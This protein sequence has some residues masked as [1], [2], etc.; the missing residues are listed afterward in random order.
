R[1]TR[2]KRDWSSDVCSSDLVQISG[3]MNGIRGPTNENEFDF[4]QYMAGKKVF[5]QLQAKQIKTFTKFHRNTI[6][7][8]FHSL[9]KKI[10]DYLDKMP[11]PL[12]WFIQV[13]LIGYQSENFQDSMDQINKLGLLYLFTLSGMHVYYLISI[14][15]YV[16]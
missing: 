5:N 16:T 13:L 8:V 6:F 15:R 7:S 14:V 3:K 12:G 4:R 9:R 11:Q 2:S 1:H 10:I